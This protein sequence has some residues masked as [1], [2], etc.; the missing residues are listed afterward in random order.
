MAIVCDTLEECIA[1]VNSCVAVFAYL[2]GSTNRSMI[3][4]LRTRLPLSFSRTVDRGY[5]TR[6][7]V[8]LAVT[9]FRVP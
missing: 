1:P 8:T 6:Y 3:E 2:Y 4:A 5:N 7:L 9:A